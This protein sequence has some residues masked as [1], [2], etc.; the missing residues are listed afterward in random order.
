MLES[1]AQ[2][3]GLFFFFSAKTKCTPLQACFLWEASHAVQVSNSL[4]T[5]LI[6]LHQL[7][8]PRYPPLSYKLCEDKNYKCPDY[9]YFPIELKEEA[10]N[11]AINILV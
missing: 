9:G 11:M 4:I 5:G 3:T 7:F 2:G 6:V 1:G 8:I 10:I